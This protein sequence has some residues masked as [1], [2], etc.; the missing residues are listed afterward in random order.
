MFNK[1]AFSI[2]LALGLLACSS[3]SDPAPGGGGVPNI[4]EAGAR[5]GSIADIQ[6]LNLV[7]EHTTSFLY[8]GATGEV[9]LCDGFY[10]ER[11]FDSPYQFGSCRI[12]TSDILVTGLFRAAFQY[13]LYGFAA[14]FAFIIFL[15]LLVFCVFYIRWTG[16]LKGVTE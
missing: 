12:E 10:N 3:D 1:I 7:E 14:A 11:L 2:V 4:P 16:A 15:F 5:G 6:L 9:E 13:N 8:N